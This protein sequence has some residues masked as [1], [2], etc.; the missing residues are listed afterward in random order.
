M[1][2]LQKV[3]QIQSLPH[4]LVLIKNITNQTIFPSATGILLS[5]GLQLHDPGQLSWAEIFLR[6]RVVQATDKDLPK[7]Q[8][9]KQDV[10][11]AEWFQL[12]KA[13]HWKNLAGQ[14]LPHY[15][16]NPLSHFFSDTCT[17]T[18]FSTFFLKQRPS[19]FTPEC[20]IINCLA[21]C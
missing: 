10:Q 12:P 13:I 5:Q 6:H 20:R 4:C 1:L 17:C 9:G 7:L 11:K 8:T 21:F 15:F 14:C 2:L 16:S 18:H 19:I 3:L